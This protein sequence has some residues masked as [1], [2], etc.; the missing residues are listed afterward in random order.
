MP[1][2]YVISASAALQT[3]RANPVHALLST[4]GIIIGVAA[5]V[6]ILAL[7]DGMEAFGREQ[8]A[9]TTDFQSIQV[10][11]SQTERIDGILVQR[12]DVPTFTVED[13]SILRGLIS[14]SAA[15]AIVQIMGKEI[16]LEGDTSSAGAFLYKTEPGIIRVADAE[17]VAGREMSDDDVRDGLQIAVITDS[18]AARLAPGMEAA[19]LIG[20]YIHVDDSEIEIV[21][22]VR[23]RGVRRPAAFIPL[24]T[25]AES[26]NPPILAVRTHT[27]EQTPQVRDIIETW[28]DERFVDGSD[29]FQIATNELRIAQIYRGILL[30]K[31][32]MGIITGISV[33]VG[34]I[35]VM[36]VL[37]VSI[38]ERTKEIGVRRSSGARRSD[39]VIQF[40]SESMALSLTGCFLGLVLGFAGVF[41]FVPV[42]RYVTG[43]PF[44]AAFGWASVLI[45]AIAGLVLGLVFGT[46]PAYRAS[47]LL[48]IEAL[49]RE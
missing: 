45:V 20:R 36:N 35:G 43:V 23:E 19:T 7:A 3:L 13:A 32:V 34:G 46:Y 18:L 25:H 38:T 10:T 40:L 30:F 14:S 12:H 47:R 9:L 26:E 28:L 29:A 8:I 4:L 1:R 48:P 33:V 41:A 37:L 11:P 2:S 6:A 27:V 24:T 39:I 16:Q 15:V 17:L 31:I 42:I 21:G 22:L 49:R 5:L 44:Q